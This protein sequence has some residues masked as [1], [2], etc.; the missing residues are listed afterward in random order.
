MVVCLG[1]RAVRLD[2]REL[3]VGLAELVWLGLRGVETR[4]EKARVL[5]RKEVKQGFCCSWTRARLG[6]GFE[7][8]VEALEA[9]FDLEM[10]R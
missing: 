6:S 4:G 5:L 8:S 3:G 1:A 2:A 10:L 7:G 9:R